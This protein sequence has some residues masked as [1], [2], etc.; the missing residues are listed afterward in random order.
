MREFWIY[1][2]ARFALF[3]AAWGLVAG[4][5]ALLNDGEVPLLWPLLIGALISMALS[6]VLLNR[7]RQRFVDAVQHRAAK[8]VD[9][10]Q[11]D[12]D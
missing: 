12:R 7:L 11:H 8:G 9:F 4:I 10:E 5:W 1:T 6:V 3:F 2:V